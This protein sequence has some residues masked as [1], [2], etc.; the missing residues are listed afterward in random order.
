M[1]NLKDISDLKLANFA[2]I[3]KDA[4]TFR[5]WKKIENDSFVPAIGKHNLYKGVKLYMYLNGYK[6][7]NKEECEIYNNF[8]L[9]YSAYETLESNLNIDTN[10]LN[11]EVKE[12]IKSSNN[13]ALK[14]IKQILEDIRSI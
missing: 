5:N 12:A 9:L 8:D 11:L 2:G 13:T 6:E 1:Y 7:I 14:T 10:N 3:G 4:K